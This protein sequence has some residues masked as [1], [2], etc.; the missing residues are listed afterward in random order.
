MVPMEFVRTLGATELRLMFYLNTT[1]KPVL[2]QRELAHETN[3]SV[4]S[5]REALKSL[6]DRGLIRY[7][8]STTGKN[9]I[10]LQK[11]N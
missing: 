6:R 8:S 10:E 9:F 1:D 3:A 11:F 7:K 2:T 5:I 4:R